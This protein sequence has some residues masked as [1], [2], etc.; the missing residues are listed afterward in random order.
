MITSLLHFY[1][2]TVFDD[3]TNLSLTCELVSGQSYETFS[4]YA[5]SIHVICLPD[6]IPENYYTIAL[7]ATNISNLR[8]SIANASPIDIDYL[9]INTNIYEQAVLE[10]ELIPIKEPIDFDD[11][12]I[13]NEFVAKEISDNSESI[14]I[15]KFDNNQLFTE[16]IFQNDFYPLCA[17]IIHENSLLNVLGLANNKS[18]LYELT[19]TGGNYSETFFVD[20]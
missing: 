11:D 20:A 1:V 14:K 7:E 10:N 13:K 16:Y 4:N 12:G 9:Y 6:N 5:D 19:E 15:F 3:V 8:T 17:G 2:Q 18:V